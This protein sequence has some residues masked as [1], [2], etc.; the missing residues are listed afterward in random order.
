M[1]LLSLFLACANNLEID[2]STPAVEVKQ[3]A[4]LRDHQICDFD[5]IDLLGRDVAISD[6]YGAP[7]VL[8]VSAAWCGPCIQAA[9]EMQSKVEA[10]PEVTFLTVLVED[11]GGQSPDETDISDWLSQ[12]GISGAP[13]WGSSRELITQDPLELKDH[14]YLSGWP[15]FYFIDS[16]GHVQEYMRGYDSNTIIQKASELN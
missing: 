15:T 2:S 10:L 7:I 16:E 1:L 5:A 12:H 3:C 4:T 13:V 14:L 9:S 8:D 11:T 6:L